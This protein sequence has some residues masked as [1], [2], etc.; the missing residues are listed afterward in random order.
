ML[1][2]QFLFIACLFFFLA[3]T[4][5]T[6]EGWV[7]YKIE[8]PQ[9]DWIKD[10]DW[11]KGL[12]Q[13]YGEKK[14][15]IQKNYY[16]KEKY[17]EVVEEGS[18][19]RYNVLNQS[20]GLLYAWKQ[21]DKVAIAQ[22]PKAQNPLVKLAGIEPLDEKA[23]IMGIPCEAAWVNMGMTGYKIWYNPKHLPMSANYYEGMVYNNLEQMFGAIGCI[24]L[25]I[26][27]PRMM[28]MTAIEIN[29]VPLN[30]EQFA[31]PDF[32]KVVRKR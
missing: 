15:G 18:T 7:T 31:I 16:K 9:P 19:K 22:D 12:I 21:Q 3:A 25:K 11:E 10:A 5:Q 6:F 27:M 29:G 2:K 4:A 28:T 30:D 23:T 32:E 17:M 14:Y 1:K 8:H 20:N 26:E 13:K 24:P